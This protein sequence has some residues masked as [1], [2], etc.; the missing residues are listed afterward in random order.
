MLLEDA[1]GNPLV[2]KVA[3]ANLVDDSG[4]IV[5]VQFS[6][7][8]RV[9]IKD[10]TNSGTSASSITVA[11]AF[12]SIPQQDTVWALGRHDDV[13]TNEVKE[14][15]ILAL[16]HEEDGI[17]ITASQYDRTKYDEIDKDIPVE[18][19]TYNPLPSKDEPVPGPETVLVE[20]VTTN[21][22][23]VDG[24]GTGMKVQISW[25]TPV[26][27]VVDTAGNSSVIPY[28]YL[29]HFEIHHNLNDDGKGNAFT[30]I[31]NI[32][33]SSTTSVSYTHLTLP[34]KA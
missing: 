21:A 34:T 9:E 33:G 24:R 20:Q 8:S 15:R 6:E 19:T 12:S 13:S 23:V 27:T 31:Q 18:T 17:S 16:G 30:K 10:I 11:G 5:A 32:P 29:S 2:T 4:D 22:T 28:R 26:E 3:A 7:D 25:S 1:S 14:Y